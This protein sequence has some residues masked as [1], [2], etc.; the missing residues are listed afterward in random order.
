MRGLPAMLALLAALAAPAS[1]Q[2]A[3][4]ARD[5][6]AP[7]PACTLSVL[8]SPAGLA[9]TREALLSAFA[10]RGIKVFAEIDHAA[11]AVEA[12]LAMPP[13]QVLVVGAPRV[14][15]PLM[16]AHP[17]LALDLPLRLL[18]RQ[19]ATGQ[20]EVVMRRACHLEQLHGLPPQTLQSLDA[21]EQL[22]Q[23]TL[24]TLGE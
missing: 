6:P 2:T 17:D 7:P 14:G 13:A 23:R 5:R 16:Q 24:H 1:A 11:A 4:A 15:T 20:A 21:L 10:A 22:V 8:P 3:T 18:L 9:R 19:S 12:G